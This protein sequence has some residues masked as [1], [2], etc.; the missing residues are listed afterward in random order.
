MSRVAEWLK[1]AGLGQFSSD[2]NNIDE[3][4]FLALQMQDYADYKVMTQE[5][6]RKLFSLLQ[7]LKR[8][9]DGGAKPAAQPLKA[10]P[11]K[12]AAAAAPARSQ[13]SASNGSA[14]SGGARPELSGIQEERIKVCVRKRPLFKKEADRGDNDVVKTDNQSHMQV[15]EPK[16]KVDLTKFTEEHDFFFD[17]VLDEEANNQQVYERCGSPLVRYVLER[18]GKATCFAYGQ[19]GSGKT[20]T[21]MG[22]PDQPGLYFL[23]ADDIF[24]LK[25]ER[26]Y[27]EMTVWVSFFEIYGGKLYDLLNDRRKLVARADAKQVVNIVGLQETE[28]TTVG[29]LMDAL[30]A[31]HEAR[32]TA[33]TGANMDS[34]RSHAVLQIN[35]KRKGAK[36]GKLSF[37]DLA[38]SERASDVNDN[39]RQTRIEGAEINKSLLAL[40][41]CIRALDQNS[42]HVPFRGSTLTSVLKDSFIGNCRTVMCA[43]VS[44]GT[45]SC[46]H[47]MN[48]LRYANRVKQLKGDN[49]GGGLNPGHNAYMPHQGGEARVAPVIGQR[50]AG[51]ARITPVHVVGV[52]NQ[53]NQNQNNNIGWGA[54]QDARRRSDDRGSMGDGCAAAAADANDIEEEELA[55]S[56]DQLA[57]EELVT[58]ILEEEDD[59]VACHRQQIEDNMALVQEEMGLLTQVEMP[60]GSV[61]SYVMS[62]DRVLQ[63]KVEAVNKL[64]SRLQEFQQRL[65]E[66]ETLS[67]TCR[68]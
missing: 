11:K 45:A 62:L 5:D 15:L 59:V 13:S 53:N 60:G 6:R 32:S 33:A 14:S 30:N 19:T 56:Q 58:N 68:M 49:K 34:S 10:L 43:N 2:F 31:G 26:G 9:L 51:N 3:D 12:N 52:Q 39:D 48:T 25:R 63:R 46:E 20:H 27:D 54:N 29:H 18:Q 57:Y 38:G 44:P 47:T 67:K 1:S 61:E 41:E 17:E 64:R 65:K 28:V 37:I 24:R 55:R 35:F 23:A 22:N 42:K 66:E 50:Q 36:A 8:E 4:G 16:I 7:V 40:K 21:M